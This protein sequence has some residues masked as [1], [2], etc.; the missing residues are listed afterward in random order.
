MSWRPRIACSD[1][2]FPLAARA[3]R[4]ARVA[5]AGFDAV[6]L[7][8]FPD[9]EQEAALLRD[10]RGS[11]ATLRAEVEA[12]GLAV[13]DLFLIPSNALA[14]AG[15]V[16][17][18]DAD[19]RRRQRELFAA[20]VSCARAAGSP[21]MTVLPGLAWPGRRHEG[22]AVA[23][24]EL[25]WRAE[26]AAAHGLG[27]RVE[28]HIGSIVALP[29]LVLDLAEAVPELTL[30]LDPGHFAYQDVALERTLPLA[31]RTTLLHVSGAAAAGERVGL[32][33]PWEANAVD[34]ARLFAA[35]A[36]QAGTG[37]AAACDAV[38]VEYV[39]MGKW[40]AHATDVPAAIAATAADVRALLAA[41]G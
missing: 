11:A 14:A 36:A 41:A 23:C 26:Y 28:P 31:G 12:S 2:S 3:E 34:F 22:W 33:I 32:H 1:Y 18:P 20:A 25:A 10:P 7:G 9:A 38:C 39:A 37:S 17:A 29:E 19:D 30:A 40:G 6:V 13:V 35:L 8:L 16:N 4:L 24:A 21:A 5:E 27:L 15:A